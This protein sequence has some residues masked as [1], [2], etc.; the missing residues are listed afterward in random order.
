LSTFPW[1]NLLDQLEQ[2]LVD[3]E[4]PERRAA[5]CCRLALLHWDVRGDR[6]S[7]EHWIGRVDHMSS[8]AVELRRQLLLDGG[9]ATAA[10]NLVEELA[11]RMDPDSPAAGQL[12]LQAGLLWMLWVS[13]AS[14][15]A[16]CC[17]RAG[18]SLGQDHNLSGLLEISLALEGRSAE[19][20]E[21]AAQP[22][23]SLS[24]L[25][26]AADA[27]I[28][29]PEAAAELL[30]RAAAI[31]DEDP[32]ILELLLEVNARLGRAEQRVRL[33]QKKLEMLTQHGP[34]SSEVLG[35]AF[36]LSR[37]LVALGRG[38]EVGELLAMVD[39]PLGDLEATDPLSVNPLAWSSVLL[40]FARR[41]QA[42]RDRDLEK[43]TEVYLA[44]A[45]ATAVPAVGRVYRLRAAQLMPSS[46]A[47]QAEQLLRQNL[48]GN[49]E[50]RHS[51][52]ALE[53]LL[54]RRG[55]METLCA[56]YQQQ[57]DVYPD[58]KGLVLRKAAIVAEAHLDNQGLAASLLR[59]CLAVDPDPSTYGDLQRLYRA[60]QSGP[61]LMEAYRRE[62]DTT[63]D[64]AVR[65]LLWSVLA[66]LRLKLDQLED[67]EAATVE[68][69]EGMADD[70]L[71]LAVLVSVYDS[72]DRR[73]E[74]RQTLERQ[75]ATLAASGSRAGSLLHLARVADLEQ[76]ARSYLERAIKLD[77]GNPQVLTGLL[78]HCEASGEYDDA[79][80]WGLELAQAVD[81]HAAQAAQAYVRVGEIYNKHQGDGEH[82][83][84]AYQKALTFQ[85]DSLPALD[86]LCAIYRERADSNALAELLERR[87]ELTAA[88]QEADLWTELARVREQTGAA[89]EDVVDALSKACVSPTE[90]PV[91]V[92]ELERICRMEGR[93]EQLTQVLLSL[94]REA[95]TLERLVV[96]LTELGDLDTLATVL[97]DLIDL[98]ED[99]LGRA[100]RTYDLGRVLEQLGRPDEAISRYEQVLEGVPVHKPALQALQRLYDSAGHTSAL[101]RVLELELDVEQDPKRR[102]ELLTDLAAGLESIGQKGM[103]TIRLEEALALQSDNLEVILALQRLYDPNHPLD[104][105]RVLVTH[106]GV[107]TDS[108]QKSALCLRAGELF[109][110][111]GAG[112]QALPALREAF[113][114]APG[115]RGGFTTYEA[116]C[117]E[118]EQWQELMQLYD[119]ALAF[120][121]HE[122]GKA[123]RP[124]DLYVRKGQL[125]LNH[126]GQ[127]GEAAAS[128]L[129]ALERDPKSESVMK[130]LESIYL[131]QQD[132]RGLIMTFQHRAR[133]VPNNELFRLE[134]LRQAARLATGRLPSDSPEARELWQEVHSIDPTDEEALDALERIYEDQDLTEQLADLLET[135]L[136][137]AVA[138]EDTVSLNLRLANLCEKTLENP[139]RAATAYERVREIQEHNEES[140]KALSRIYE[141]TGLWE[142][143]VDV[144]K[145]LVIMEADPNER[146][147][148]YF[149]CGSIVES[150]FHQDDQAIAYYEAAINETAACLPAIHGLRDL[151]LRREEWNKALD[152]L[153]LEVQLWEEV[154]EQAGVL[155]R[156]GEIRLRN[157]HDV[158]GAVDLYEDALAIDRECH[159][160]AL[161]LFDIFFDGGEARRALEMSERLVGRLAKEGDPQ[162][163]S[164]FFSRRGQLQGQGAE[165]A[166]AVES[167]VTALDLWPD[168]LEA[169]DW[170]IAICRRSPEAYD[171]AAIFRDLEAVY[172]REENQAAVGHVL[173]AA[174]ALS[175]I[176][177]DAETALARYQEAMESAPGDLA[178]V[179]SLAN[180]LVRIR[181]PREA[182]AVLEALVR[183]AEAPGVQ[184]RALIRVGEVWSDVT[185]DP[186]NA[187]HAYQR[188][189][190]I[191]PAHQDAM[192]SMA[193]EQFLVGRPDEA[194]RWLTILL[195]QVVM[196]SHARPA[197]VSRYAH[198]MGV[199]LR[200]M[201]DTAGATKQFQYALQLDE[202][203]GPAAI[204]LAHQM[205][206]MGDLLGAKQALLRALDGRNRPGA[207]AE[208]LE[209][210]RALAALQLKTSDV[211]GAL[212]QY[213]TVI[214]EAGRVEDRLALAEVHAERGEA[215]QA[216]R[217]LVPVLE[218]DSYNPHALRLLADIHELSGEQERTML[219]LQVM[220]MLG[221][222]G[223]E[224]RVKLAALRRLYAI[225]PANAL[226][227]G[228]RQYLTAYSEDR[229]VQRVWEAVR[230][231]LER[232][233]P[234]DLSG[235]PPQPLSQVG[236]AEF[237]QLAEWCVQFVSANATV[238]VAQSV[239]GG[240]A[241][242]TVDGGRLV[243]DRLFLERPPAEVAFVLGR[244]LE[245][246]RS[247]HALLS[248]LA[249]DD[250]LLLGELIGG[251]L[252]PAEARNDLAQEFRRGVPRRMSK[253]L[254]D[255]SSAYLADIESGVEANQTATWFAGIDRTA[256]NTGLVAC[257]DISSAL[258]MVAQL[259]G[260]EVAVGPRGEI[261]VQLVTDG[262]ELVQFFLSDANIKLRG[263]LARM[264]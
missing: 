225:K 215:E 126:L 23:A 73:Q 141:A 90:R 182:V 181:R 162:R 3:S 149:K 171:F 18:A 83:A 250:R 111:N 99:D 108:V 57:A 211:R 242:D 175:E 246:L 249:F 91:A 244:N 24:T 7:A 144:L 135:R 254:D 133:L 159:P 194:H 101:A 207:G 199:V 49:P 163:R 44:M 104:L 165:V 5:V 70:P 4:T 147:L 34:R 60:V 15:A 116:L 259:G 11:S 75:A 28:G 110:A 6:T 125:Q 230:E 201:G 168:N 213:D 169:L 58:E 48:Q 179:K 137:L 38:E 107:E 186:Q 115:N 63:S 237:R 234:L 31:D 102:V 106:A 26:L 33:M 206:Q 173:V 124:L 216:R 151:Y 59:D 71:A 41:D 157:L 131:Q 122:G 219:V 67:A 228:L 72:T 87:I 42:V 84:Q 94:P 95:D 140:L 251:L 154:K 76:E 85:P 185:P 86:G 164:R 255:I 170:L 156:M 204:A 148:L 243:I 229:H 132:W 257:N 89:I 158:R 172:R 9:D 180:L 10:A 196:S 155:A 203:N 37:L 21:L 20:V 236:Q 177:G 218:A 78:E 109:A 138:D 224:D 210:R 92:K 14:R 145:D 241:V 39:P 160:A 121:D 200:Q 198:Y 142:Q 130:L 103:A 261:A 134:S 208:T 25:V 1:E 77:P 253:S 247:G 43:L 240:A 117:Y 13:D 195:D 2:E 139:K 190:A 47:R 143:C 46:S 105:A 96:A 202:N 80:Q 61:R 54:L 74:L 167:L 221:W 112:D 260:Q 197:A 17:L 174:G 187:M 29:Q 53:I 93:L 64:P 205:G 51:A 235:E 119:R 113:L 227:D 55:E 232:L 153:E 98:A 212:E 65:S 238:L 264:E 118:Q 50:D 100:D 252:Q 231:A 19:L 209:V 183:R 36:D 239:P 52:R 97:A 220:E 123:Y 248:R 56:H 146:S 16:D 69:L 81:E 222:A 178:P 233:F 79:I 82:A 262:P 88:G 30:E 223:R 136:A 152:T 263:R 27:Q 68:A 62:A 8:P 45:E 40:R 22:D 66:A 32:L 258:R 176:A 217:A 193:Q 120:V 214:R 226:D 245:Y 150:R 184:V 192:L 35:L 188:A 161:A 166:Q 114:C 256:N 191:D 129:L 12:F 189:L 128:L 127:P